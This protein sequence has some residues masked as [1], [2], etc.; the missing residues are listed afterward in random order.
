MYKFENLRNQISIYA[1]GAVLSE[2]SSEKDL[3]VDGY[4]FNPSIFRNHG[5]EDYISYCK[6]ILKLVDNKPVSLEVIA[7]DEREMLDQAKILNELSSNVYVKIPIMFTNGNSTVDVIKELASEKIKLNITAIFLIDQIKEILPHLKDSEAI[8][9]IFAGRLFDSGF[10]AVEEMKK[11][12]E[13]IKIESNCKSLWAS[14]RMSFDLVNAIRAKTDI[15]TMQ[16]SQLKKLKLFGKDRLQY[17]R[18]TVNQF[19]KDAKESN[20]KI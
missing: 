19:Y 15:I 7:D 14:T 17:S 5:A 8:L 11:I 2:L 4:T 3:N 16:T 9:S 13:I 10:D 20:Y 18:E 1:D 12:N 6:E